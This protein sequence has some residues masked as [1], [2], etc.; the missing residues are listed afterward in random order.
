[1][2]TIES[3]RFAVWAKKSYLDTAEL[4]Y[5]HILEVQYF[6]TF[7]I[8]DFVIGN[9]IPYGKLHNQQLFLC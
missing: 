7:S 4:A 8:L 6:V 3:Q 9:D 2:Q 5:E 1:M